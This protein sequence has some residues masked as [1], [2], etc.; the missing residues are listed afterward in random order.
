MNENTTPS[1]A[2]VT[3]S[4]NGVFLVFLFHVIIEKPSGAKFKSDSFDRENLLLFHINN[5]HIGC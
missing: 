4:V 5:S 1:E 2:D 3:P